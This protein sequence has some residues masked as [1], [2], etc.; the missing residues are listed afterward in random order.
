M[1]WEFVEHPCDYSCLPGAIPSQNF[2]STIHSSCCVAFSLSVQGTSGYKTLQAGAGTN[3]RATKQP[4][5]AKQKIPKQQ[6]RKQNR[7]T[8]KLWGLLP[9]QQPD[10]NSVLFPLLVLIIRKRKRMEPQ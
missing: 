9:P 7:V 5:V 1:L 8:V 10:C 3:K 2:S 6:Q 4:T